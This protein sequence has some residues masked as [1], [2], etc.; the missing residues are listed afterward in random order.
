MG[1]FLQGSDLS[2]CVF[3]PA[4]ANAVA[5]ARAND[6]IGHV[7]PNAQ[8][9]SPTDSGYRAGILLNRFSGTG[10]VI[11]GPATRDLEEQHVDREE[12]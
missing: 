2:R 5:I 10:S 12:P 11:N 7:A 3:E 1:H 4:H 8:L 6:R 9:R